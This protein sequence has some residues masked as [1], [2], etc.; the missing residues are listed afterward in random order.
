MII[1]DGWKSFIIAIHKIGPLQ[2]VS[3][4]FIDFNSVLSTRRH[5]HENIRSFETRFEAQLSRFN[6]HGAGKIPDAFVALML[7][8]NSAVEDIKRVSILAADVNNFTHL[9]G[10]EPTVCEM[11]SAVKYASNLSVLRQC[12]QKRTSTPNDTLYGHQVNGT[13]RGQGGVNQP[14]RSQKF[15]NSDKIAEA[16]K[17]KACH[18]CKKNC[19]TKYG[20]CSPDHNEDDSLKPCVASLDTPL[21]PLPNSHNPASTN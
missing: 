12:D 11:L 20:P 21:S 1:D 8:M 6:A 10:S 15:K 3:G 5:Q 2:F 9:D 4:V 14:R 18:Y 7:F 16:E 13:G 17:K 19:L